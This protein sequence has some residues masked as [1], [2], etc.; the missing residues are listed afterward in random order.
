[1][2]CRNCGNEMDPQAVV[3]VKCGVPKGS[4]NNFCH[5]CGQPTS[6]MAV[7]CTQCGVSLTAPTPNNNAN[8][9][10]LY[11]NQKSKLVAGLLAIFIGTLGIHNFYLGHTGK[12]VAQLLITIFTCG[13]GGIAVWIWALIEGIQLLTG[14]IDVDAAGVPLKD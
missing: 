6:P 12:A 7:V 5:N 1:M 11:P 9:S 14:K 10:N 4:G 13:F 3:C 2:F 8:N